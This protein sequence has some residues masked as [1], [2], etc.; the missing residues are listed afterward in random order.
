[1]RTNNDI[2]KILFSLEVHTQRGQQNNQSTQSLGYPVM[3][4]GGGHL[5]WRQHLPGKGSSQ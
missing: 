3:T 5:G 2:S 4:T 1:M